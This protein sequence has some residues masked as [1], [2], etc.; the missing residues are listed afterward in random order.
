[1]MKN[2]F[3]KGK[4][5]L[6]ILFGATIGVFIGI[7]FA[8]KSGKETRNQINSKAEAV[9]EG[10]NYKT[11]ELKEKVVEKAEKVQDDIAEIK[12]ELKEK[13]LETAERVQ[14]EISVKT[15][16]LKEKVKEKVHAIKSTKEY[17]E[18]EEFFEDIILDSYQEMGQQDDN[19]TSKVNNLDID[20]AQ[21]NQPEQIDTERVTEEPK[22]RRTRKKTQENRAEDE[23]KDEPKDE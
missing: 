21:D 12:E 19:D 5:V 13:V 16:E 3:S 18:D 23:S 17:D 14:E 7:L 9:K 4:T 6:S 15:D 10:I 11:Y 2:S 20:E 8:P 1:M 22:K